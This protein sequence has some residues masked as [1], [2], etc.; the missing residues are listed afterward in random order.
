[1]FKM[2]FYKKYLIFVVVKLIYLL[3]N[4]LFLVMVWFFLRSLFEGINVN[5][6]FMILCIIGIF[7]VIVV[8]GMFYYYVFFLGGIYGM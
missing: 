6:V 4:I 2:F 1:M 8:K 5:K 7:V 3:F